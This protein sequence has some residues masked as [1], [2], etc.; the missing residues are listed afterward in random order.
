LIS[1]GRRSTQYEAQCSGR[2]RMH[3]GQVRSL[4]SAQRP[5]SVRRLRSKSGDPR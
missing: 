5:R 2:P 1:H 4:Q 3:D